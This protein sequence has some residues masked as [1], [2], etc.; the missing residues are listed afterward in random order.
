MTYP[1]VLVT[2]AG[3]FVGGR[4]VEALHQAGAPHI[5]AATAS[6]GNPHLSV[7][8]SSA[9]AVEVTPYDLFDPASLA[10]AL[11]GAEAVIHCA[12]DDDPARMAEGLRRLLGASRAAGV[13]K[14]VQL[15]SVAVY[16]AA[17]GE[18]VEDTPPAGKLD[19]YA[20]AK[21]KSEADCRAAAG[22][23]MAVAV[24]RPALVYGPGGALWTTP[25]VRRLAA[26][27]QGLGPGGMGRANLVHV[28][29]VARCAA[30]VAGEA[31]GAYAV[32]NL[33]GPEAPTWNDYLA[34]FAD[35]LETPRPKGVQSTSLALAALRRPAAALKRKL[36]KGKAP[37]SLAPTWQELK[38]F[39]LDAVYRTD[40]LAAM[41]FEPSVSLDEGLA[42]CARWAR[43]QGMV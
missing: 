17:T 39:R 19:A 32:F 29:D 5:K 27:W 24:L 10:R 12:R 41:G 34:R 7:H 8:R 18:V 42:D 4:V 11:H 1:R 2:G 16:G 20:R 36:S 14:V 28:D 22:E 31:L 23:G 33:S 40:K 30:F 43:E 13:R 15:S 3:G 38:L 21:L 37:A 25:F 35:V 9:A 6:L 26:G